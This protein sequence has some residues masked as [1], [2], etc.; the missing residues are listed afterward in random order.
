MSVFV[1]GNTSTAYNKAGI[2]TDF[3]RCTHTNSVGLPAYADKKLKSDLS[4]RAK[5]AAV[6]AWLGLQLILAVCV[7]TNT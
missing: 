5:R 6:G 7:A 3:N 2:H 1:S 4:K